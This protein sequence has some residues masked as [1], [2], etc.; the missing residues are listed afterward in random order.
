MTNA[1]GVTR[2]YL[3]ARTTPGGADGRQAGGRAG[4]SCISNNGTTTNFVN[5]INGQNDESGYY[6]SFRPSRPL[7]PLFL[8]LFQKEP[9]PCNHAHTYSGTKTIYI[10]P[11]SSYQPHILLTRPPP[12]ASPAR[13]TRPRP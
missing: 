6:F 8:F 12:R 7:P 2:Y 1:N 3:M 11:P 10:E 9:K 4:L 5:S 13:A